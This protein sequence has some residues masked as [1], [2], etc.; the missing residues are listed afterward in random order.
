MA[1]VQPFASVSITIC[2]EEFYHTHTSRQ[3]PYSDD[4]E[5]IY[6]VFG[7]ALAETLIGATP[8][9]LS[10]LLAEVIGFLQDWEEIP[11]H[12]LWPE[13]RELEDDFVKAARRIVEFWEERDAL[14]ASQGEAGEKD[15]AK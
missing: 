9:R 11:T 1:E 6:D 3:Y 2:T 12:L 13:L 14:L 4:G 8:P 5:N 15:G 7:I 10:C